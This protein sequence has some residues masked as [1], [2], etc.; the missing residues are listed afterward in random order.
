MK[1]TEEQRRLA[2]YWADD[3]GKTPTPAG[4]WAWILTDLLRDR[5]A[6]LATA[7]ERYARMGIAMSI[8]AAAGVNPTICGLAG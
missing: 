3:P 8:G 6:D 4:H 2:L 1:P 7:A 5:K